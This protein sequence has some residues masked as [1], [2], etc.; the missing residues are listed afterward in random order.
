MDEHIVSTQEFLRA[1]I[2]TT[3]P[4]LKDDL[5]AAHACYNAIF[6]HRA[7]AQRALLE[8]RLQY[9][10][11]KDPQY[12]DMDRKIMLEGN[13]SDEQ[14]KYDL[15]L[16]LEKALEQRIEIIKTLLQ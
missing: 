4:E 1:D 7:E 16:G 2:P 10:H 13:T 8:K 15:L 6:Q 11:P 12:T 3:V 9:L 5:R 14:A